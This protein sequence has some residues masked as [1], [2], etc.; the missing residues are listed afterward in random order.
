MIVERDVAV[1][2]VIDSPTEYWEMMSEHVSPA[3]AA[4]KRVDELTKERI[5][6]T[7]IENVHPH[8]RNGQVRVPGLA[9]CV[10]GTR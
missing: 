4:L 2:L 8:Q 9:R 3:V 10:S 6:R 7:V 5:A 1:E